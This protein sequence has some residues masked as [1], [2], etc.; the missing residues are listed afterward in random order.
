MWI[1]FSINLSLSRRGVNRQKNRYKTHKLG[2]IE[3]EKCEFKPEAIGMD[4]K[5]RVAAEKRSNIKDNR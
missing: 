3:N 5:R 2:V 4:M 1:R